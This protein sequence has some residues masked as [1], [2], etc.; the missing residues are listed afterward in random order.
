MSHLWYAVSE[1]EPSLF[2]QSG[3]S[4]CQALTFTG[5][6]FLTDYTHT[7]RG[8]NITITCQLPSNGVRLMEFD[9]FLQISFVVETLSF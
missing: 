4:F 3:N 6:V 5:Q 8:S 2:Q 1:N 9:R 7:D